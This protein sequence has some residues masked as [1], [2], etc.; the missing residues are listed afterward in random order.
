LVALLDRRIERVHIHV[1]DLADS[2]RCRQ[3][4]N[5]FSGFPRANGGRAVQSSF[6]SEKT[7]SFLCIQIAGRNTVCTSAHPLCPEPPRG[8]GFYP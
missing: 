2:W 8:P 4:G 7:P 6:Y 3:N 1:D 5:G